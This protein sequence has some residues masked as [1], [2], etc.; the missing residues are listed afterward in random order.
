MLDSTTSHFKYNRSGIGT[1][2]KEFY[3]FFKSPVEGFNFC[4]DFFSENKT[5]ILTKSIY[6]DTSNYIILTREKLNSIFST[7]DKNLNWDKFYKLYPKSKGYNLISK[8]KYNTT[9]E[10]ALVYIENCC[11][12]LCG[13]GYLILLQKKEMWRIVNTDLIW[14]S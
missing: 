1:R 5:I 6:T 8:I 12:R 11:G 7:S 3:S 2:E 4:V 14:V 10:L 13:S 9:K